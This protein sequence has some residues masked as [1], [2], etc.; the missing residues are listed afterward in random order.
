[1]NILACE[2]YH[3]DGIGIRI[4]NGMNVNINQ[5]TIEHNRLAGVVAYD[6]KKFTPLNSEGVDNGGINHTGFVFSNDLNKVI[7]ESVQIFDVT[8]TDSLLTIWGNGNT[9]RITGEVLIRANSCSTVQLAGT[10]MGIAVNGGH[11]IDIHDVTTLNMYPAN[12][13]AYQRMAITT[14]TLKKAQE[15]YAVQPAF[16]IS[17][18]SE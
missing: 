11:W 14:G 9:S 5:S 1:M 6:L 16:E 8:K 2:I 3:N 12:F 4:G 7:I 15:N 17:D 13:L 18:G 10:D